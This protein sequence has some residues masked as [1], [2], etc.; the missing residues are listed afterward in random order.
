ML[1]REIGKLFPN[2]KTTIAYYSPTTFCVTLNTISENDIKEFGNGKISKEKAE[3]LSILYH[4]FTHHVDHIST[5]WGQKNI[6]KLF[7]AVNGRLS[8]DEKKFYKIIDLKKTEQQ[9]HYDQYYTE[10]Y[11]IIPWKTGNGNWKWILTTGFKFTDN[12]LPNENDPIFFIR[13]A[14]NDDKN[15]VRVPFSVASLLETNSTKE[16]IKMMLSYINS[17]SPDEK[18]VENAIY[19]RY[20]FEDLIYNQ[21]L[22]VYNAAVH[23]TANH[24]HLSDVVQSFDISSSIATLALNLPYELINQ[25]PINEAK[26]AVWGDRPKKMA[27]NND[28][29]FLFYNLLLNYVPFFENDKEFNLQRLLTANN[30]PTEDEILAVINKEIDKIVDRYNEQPNFKNNFTTIAKEGQRILNVR[31]IAGTKVA[32]SDLIS[33]HSYKPFIICNDTDFPLEDLSV[34]AILDKLP[35]DNLS[36][37]QWYSFADTI[38]KKMD[39]F[40]NVRGL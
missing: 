16:E 32:L 34:S 24:L 28:Y 27:G 11:N 9:L 30:L 26:M 14:T 1:K 6:Y 10:Q 19:N 8:L 38:D 5:L 31:G 15:L 2:I 3:N 22:A 12:G 29:G 39:D 20:I 36:V 17:L 33:N 4:E 35:I 7:D 40:Y 21:N 13:F 37:Q 25:I 18:L 23:L